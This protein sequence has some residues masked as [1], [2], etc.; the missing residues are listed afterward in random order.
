MVATAPTRLM[1]SRAS[2][3]LGTLALCV[4]QVCVLETIIFMLRYV[5]R[6]MYTQATK[7]LCLFS[8]YYS[9]THGFCKWC[10][11]KLSILWGQTV[12]TTKNW[13]NSCIH[14]ATDL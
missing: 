10:N 14:L 3:R 7:A 11:A 13:R 9:I 2:V 5:F 8:V 4:K 6:N 1:V 12:I